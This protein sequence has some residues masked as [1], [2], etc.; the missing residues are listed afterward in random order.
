MESEQRAKRSLELHIY[1]E[2]KKEG[3]RGT[4]CA[5]SINIPTGESTIYFLPIRGMYKYTYIGRGR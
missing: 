3:K 4:K 1:K 5:E 2:T